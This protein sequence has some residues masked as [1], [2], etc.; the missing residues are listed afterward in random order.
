MKSAFVAIDL[1]NAFVTNDTK[2]I[3]GK[4][5]D[6]LKS[7]KYDLVLFTKFVNKPRSNFEKQIGYKD[8]ITSPEIDFDLAVQGLAK[9]ENTFPKTSY[10]AF[11]AKGFKELL[12]KEGIGKVYICG[13]DSDSCVLATAFDAFDLGYEVRVL[14]ELS[15][16]SSGPD[17]DKTGKKIINYAIQK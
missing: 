14:T 2:E 12:E 15:K 11:K 5:R 8:C 17:F 4:I 3:P 9:P 7:N 1:Q 13:L 16:S 6:H 10:S